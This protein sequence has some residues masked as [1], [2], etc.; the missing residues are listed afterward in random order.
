MARGLIL[1]GFWLCLSSWLTYN[2]GMN[3]SLPTPTNQRRILSVSQANGLAK[4]L[5]E[6]HLPLLWIEGEISN[7]AQPSSGH[8]Y[9]TLKDNRAQ[10]RCAMFKG[11]NSRVPFKPKQGDQVLVRG[12]VSLYEGRG[13]FQLIA[14]HMEDSGVGNLQRQFEALKAKLQKEGVFAEELKTPI[15]EHPLHI[16]II[17]SPT[18]AA[19]RDILSVLKRRMPSIPVTVVPTVV[20]GQQ[21]ASEI[22]EAVN[23]AEASGLFDVLVVTRGGGSLED[24]WCFNDERLAQAI[25]QCS[26]P[27]ISA[28]GHEIDFTIA[29]FVADL[30]APTP[31]A[32]AEILSQSQNSICKTL[33]GLEH[34]LVLA[35]SHMIRHQKSVLQQLKTRLRHPGER[36]QAQSQQLDHLELRLNNAIFNRLEKKSALLGKATLHLN[37][38]HPAKQLSRLGMTLHGLQIQLNRSIKNNLMRRKDSHQNTAKRL[39]SVSPLNVL[40]RGY[41]IALDEQGKA[42]TDASSTKPGQSISVK[43]SQGEFSASVTEVK[44]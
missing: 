14:E 13:D 24:L 20:Q 31:S 21:A 23:L 44:P 10:I 5:L 3:D 26:I 41:A 36:L 28:V 27:V 33:Q 8:W 30:R 6:D 9:F 29:D 35:A 2:A 38:H 17:T 39:H 32:A 12:K 19:I 22:V 42:L 7:L 18:G 34:R 4:Q 37:S 16:G 43:L 25:H 1:A 11:R 40:A 15:P